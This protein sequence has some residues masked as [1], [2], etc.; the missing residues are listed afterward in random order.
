M[1]SKGYR[2]YLAKMLKLYK[3]ISTD[4]GVLTAEAEEIEIGTEVFTEGEEG[5]IPAQDGEYIDTAN[6]I[7]YVVE[8]GT[9]KEIVDVTPENSI[10]NQGS[11]N[12]T[13]ANPD[14]NTN[15]TGSTTEV[16]DNTGSGEGE[17]QAEE[18]K[19][20]SDNG[21]GAQEEQKDEVESLKAEIET[22]NA[23]ID[24]LRAK[25]DELQAKLDEYKAKEE[26]VDA[27]SADNKEKFNTNKPQDK[28]LEKMQRAIDAIKILNK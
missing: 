15:E 20:G 22:K 26:E 5:M 14:D 2:L 23:E 28:R 12:G 19:T 7:K 27:L 10:E 21:E 18:E 9:I 16:E 4:N 24:E 13:D 1:V 8:G 17:G 11:D 3:E 25:V 6:N